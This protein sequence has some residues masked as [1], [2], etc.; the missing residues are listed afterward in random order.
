MNHLP[1]LAAVALVIFALPN[2]VAQ[3]A[4]KPDKPG[5]LICTVLKGPTLNKIVS[6]KYPASARA[7][8][9]LGPLLLSIKIDGQGAPHDVK[10]LKGDTDLAKALSDVIDQW[11][12]QPYKLNGRSVEIQTE[13]AVK[14]HFVL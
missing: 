14:F 5:R 11:R 9:A 1:R 6:P 12:F 7:R 8:G 10:I 2:L 3:T 13:L 4:A